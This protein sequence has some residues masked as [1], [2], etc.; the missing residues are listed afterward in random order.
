MSAMTVCLIATGIFG[1]GYATGAA[2]SW[3]LSKPDLDMPEWPEPE[4]EPQWNPELISLTRKDS[5]MVDGCLTRRNPIYDVVMKTTE[6]LFAYRVT[7]D[8]W[9]NLDTGLRVRNAVHRETLDWLYKQ[10]KEDQQ[11]KKDIKYL[12][13]LTLPDL[14]GFKVTETED[15]RI[16][17]GSV[18][19]SREVLQ[20][21][22]GLLSER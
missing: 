17:I 13:K 9:M 14:L 22:V 11:D 7:S 20:D 10:W 2:F 21:V 8:N 3:K 5:G 15:G 4:P 18:V 6:G 12:R 16:K 1:L 19:L